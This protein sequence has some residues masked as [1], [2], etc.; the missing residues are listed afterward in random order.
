[1]F[2]IERRQ[3][4]L[5]NTDPQRRCYWGEHYKSEWVWSNWG[6]LETWETEDVAQRRL[7]FW[8]ELNDYAVKERGK[9]AIKEFRVV[10]KGSTHA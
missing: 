1:M 6:E 4:V 9:S 10:E 2:V 8:K 5:I 3:L 7:I